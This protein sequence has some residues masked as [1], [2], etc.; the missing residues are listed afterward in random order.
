MGLPGSGSQNDPYRIEGFSISDSD[1]CINITGTTAYIIIQ[2]CILTQTSEGFAF[3]IYLWN[4]SNC[5]VI[6][7][8][9]DVGYWG[10]YMYQCEKGRVHDSDI[11]GN[12]ACIIIQES[13]NCTVSS[14]TLHEHQG[15]GLY[16]DS[17]NYSI[18]Q[19]NVVEGQG[20]S[21]TGIAAFGPAWY[22][23][24]VNNTITGHYGSAVS[25][26]GIGCLVQNNSIT[27]NY[28]G[29]YAREL[30]ENNTITLNRIEESILCNARDDGSDNIWN[31]NWYSDY[32]GVGLYIIPGNA[33]SIDHTPKPQNVV[34]LVA[35]VSIPTAITF[36]IIAGIFKRYRRS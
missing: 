17:C 15:A 23:I 11:K 29:I 6:D 34:L 25:L 2:D 3:G 7:C 28:I 35:I 1:A 5:Y 22:C 16:F 32:M 31:S 14:N 18:A 26:E 27:Q 10:V 20:I 19:C 21:Q 9:V 33:Q 12:D 30:S 8:N 36:L 4:V 13:R 24:I